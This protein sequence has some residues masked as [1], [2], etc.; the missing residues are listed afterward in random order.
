LASVDSLA[1]TAVTV[2]ETSLIAGILADGVSADDL[3]KIAL[4]LRNRASHS[5][6]VLISSNGG[7]PV[8]VAAVSEAARGSGIKAGE[9]VKFN[10][11]RRR[12][13]RQG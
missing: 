13:W 12:R 8:L 6:V 5:V 3:R 10:G 7:Q 2:G 4:E 9:L 1:S 11:S